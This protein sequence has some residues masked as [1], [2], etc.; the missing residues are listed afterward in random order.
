MGST[1]TTTYASDVRVRGTYDGEH[2]I[3]CETPP[4]HR[5]GLLYVEIS[6][7]GQQYHKCY[8]VVAML[9][10]SRIMALEPSVVQVGQRGVVRASVRGGIGAQ[11]LCVH[12]AAGRNELVLPATIDEGFDIASRVQR[13]RS[14]VKL[15]FNDSYDCLQRVGAR[16]ASSAQEVEDVRDV[17]VCVCV[18]AVCV[19]AVCVCACVRVCV[20]VCVCLC[21]CV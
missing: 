19:W 4:W 5:S 20:C 6:F 2:C 17:C 16:T 8:T 12:L 14:A 15:I 11:N 18:W 21:V 1:Q 13:F 7:N 10:K 9:P 3:S